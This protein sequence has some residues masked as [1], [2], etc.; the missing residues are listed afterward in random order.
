MNDFVL[1]K[2]KESSSHSVKMIVV[3]LNILEKTSFTTI[4]KA[5]AQ[6]SFA[7]SLF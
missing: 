2:M 1:H 6:N 7:E 4:S 3:Q 5:V